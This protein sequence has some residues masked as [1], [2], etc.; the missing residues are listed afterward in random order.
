MQTLTL[1]QAKPEPPPSL[2][3]LQQQQ[4]PA[5]VLCCRSL[6]LLSAGTSQAWAARIESPCGIKQILPHASQGAFPIS[7]WRKGWMF[8][9]PWRQCWRCRWKPPVHG[10][11]KCSSL[12]SWGPAGGT[13]WLIPSPN[14]SSSGL[15]VPLVLPLWGAQAGHKLTN[16]VCWIKCKLGFYKKRRCNHWIGH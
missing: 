15:A 5:R 11:H 3:R 8:Q 7:S 1:S 12:Q 13:C 4:Q 14:R 2:T 6:W 16:R 10:C 9:L